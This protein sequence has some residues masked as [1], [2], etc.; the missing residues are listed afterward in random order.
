MTGTEPMF[1]KLKLTEFFVKSSW[2]EFHDKQ[3]NNLVSDTR[4]QVDG[5]MGGWVWG[6]HRVFSVFPFIKNA[7]KDKIQVC[8]C[9]HFLCEN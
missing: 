6:L 2:T 9:Y 7:K 1:T 5:W 4:L 3:T 8:Y